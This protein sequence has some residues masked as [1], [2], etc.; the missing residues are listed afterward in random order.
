M[1]KIDP[2]TI[3]DVT[4]D[5]GLTQVNRV[6]SPSSPARATTPANT[7][8]VA[9]PEPV[10]KSTTINY[11]DPPLYGVPQLQI[12]NDPG[13]S[14]GQIQFNMANTFKGDGNLLW[15][16]VNKVLRVRNIQTQTINTGVITGLINIDVAQLHVNGGNAGQFLQ[17]DGTGNLT[18]ANGGG[19]S[20]NAYVHIGLT[21]S[22]GA[23]DGALW[24][25]S[26]IGRM[27][28]NYEGQYV[29]PSPQVLDPTIIKYEANFNTSF[30]GNLIIPDGNGIYYANGDPF[31]QGGV[32]T[33]N[34]RFYQDTIYDFNGPNIN[35]G[36]LSHGATSGLNIVPNGDGNATILFNTYGNVQIFSSETGSNV[37]AWTFDTAGGLNVPGNGVVRGSYVNLVS[38]NFSQLQ[39]VDEAN[40]NIANP[41]DTTG[42]T[43]W[44]W[45]DQDGVHVQT[46]VNDPYGT[47]TW[48]LG[49]DGAISFPDNTFQLT[50]W[51][52]TVDTGNV[53][54]LG[55]IATINLDDSTSN[56]LYG[57]GV[58][59]PSYSTS[60]IVSYA[61][62]GWT[63]NI[64][65][66]GN[67][68][69]SLGTPTQQWKDLYLS[70]ATIYMN[71]VPISVNSNNAL[72][73]NG[74]EVLLTSN[75][76]G[77][78]TTGN[79]TAYNIGNVAALN[80]DGS[81]SNV[82]YGNGSFAALP[83]YGD[84][85][86]A[87]LLSN[88]D[89]N[90]ISTSGNIT[91][92]YLIGNGVQITNVNA[93]SL[94]G[95]IGET[96][97][98]AGSLVLRDNNGNVSAN[99]FVGNGS[100]LTG[101]YSNSNLESY[102][103][104]NPQPGTYSNTNVASYLSSEG[105][106]SYS[107]SN[108]T[109][110]LGSFGSNTI[111]TTGNIS[112]KLVAPS[113][114]ANRQILINDDGMISGLSQF[115][116]DKNGNVLSLAG[117]SVLKVT[118][119]ETSQPSTNLRLLPTSGTTTSYGNFY[120]QFDDFYD[121]GQNGI[122]WKGVYSTTVNT[123]GVVKA[124]AVSYANTDGTVGQVLTTYGNGITYWSTPAG[125]YGNS[126][127]TTLLSSYGSNTI[128]TTGNITGGNLIGVLA[129]GNSNVSIPTANGNVIT[130]V[131]GASVLTVYSG[132]IKVA[133]AGVIQSPGGASSI[134]LNNN[135]AN[136]PTANIT[137]LNVTGAASVTGNIVGGNISTAGA[138]SATGNVTANNFIGNISITGNVT[139]TSPN[140]SLV[141]GS[142]TS[143]FDNTGNI[144]LTNSNIF[145]G[146]TNTI[147]S[148]TVAA[149]SSNINSYTQ[150]TNQNKSAGADATAD[151]VLTADN[152]SDTVNYGDFG[153]INSGYD[154]NTPTNSLGNI[155]FAADTYLY[156]QGNTSNVSQSGGNLA[157]G[158]TVAGKNV[159]IFAGGT[160]SA[161]IVAN[162]SNT[163]VAVTGAVSA[164]GNVTGTLLVASG[165]SGDEGGELQLAKAPNSTLS[166]NLVID[167][168][169][170]RVRVFDGGGTS[171]GMYFDIAN[172]PAGVGAAVGYREVPQVA[173]GNVTIAASD[174]GKHYY[175]TT[176]GNL[177]L[178]IPNNA[179]TSFATGTA[180]SIVVQAAGN[181]L[182]NAASG[183]TL[184]MAGNSTA[185]NRVVGAYGMATLLKVASDTW[186]INGTG[187]S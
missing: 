156:A 82:L 163:G 61:E 39:W 149:F 128:S 23:P 15:D 34:V 79:V 90:F 146:V 105:I 57:N 7:T 74:S 182:V 115:T 3:I 31:S 70:N 117:V 33:G 165:G 175:S 63:G 138:I 142:Y 108:V 69:Y 97:A 32:D 20:G 8:Y 169:I 147:L 159:K 107:D 123:T 86:V 60:D 134:T 43:N 75:S 162:I 91:G 66:T 155:V 72:V 9:S 141:A 176:A 71:S 35:N 14:N 116:F 56:V 29:D 125:S 18:W 25:N 59:A 50:A 73:V 179:T 10:V 47:F 150:V 129:S 137:T 11:T 101:M 17:T 113:T 26:N 5:L 55:N 103:T 177:T 171:R 111:T 121:L 98:L 28:L 96:V 154:N 81:S 161:N 51:T 151:Y 13:G 40:L 133:G 52:G 139:G 77:I 67:S 24:Y 144:T 48:K 88:F 135:G 44:I 54:G 181:I 148:N 120:P 2:K 102:L 45:V 64:N 187:V 186:F 27:Y 157:I 167:S 119:I 124:G 80:L 164:T 16:N 118:D 30:P 153:I 114:T 76:G 92:A 152:G 1:A 12:F 65:P 160:T 6:S 85:N 130:S 41:N 58:F 22:P 168:Y 183:V 170:N 93:S 94:N 112:G 4:Q 180:I 99:Y 87:E 106:I 62:I 143:T 68:V 46:N 38:S 145:V 166:G 136:I 132:G 49:T 158:T 37:N 95:A 36:D 109:S 53:S 178:T 89:G 127:V 83:V 42:P 174:A 100:M 19:S 84:S 110:L 104:A 21:P 172:A 131:G 184:Y 140:V 126:N 185:A 122:R 78:S 173:A